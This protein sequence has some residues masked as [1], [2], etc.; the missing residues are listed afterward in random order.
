MNCGIKDIMR[1]SILRDHAD[2]LAHGLAE[3][4]SRVRRR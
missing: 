3:H 4:Y 1:P 2:A